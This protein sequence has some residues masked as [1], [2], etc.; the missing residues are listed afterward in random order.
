MIFTGLLQITDGFRSTGILI[1]ILMCFKSLLGGEEAGIWIQY[2]LKS[3]E[4]RTRRCPKEINKKYHQHQNKSTKWRSSLVSN[5]SYLFP[6]IVNWVPIYKKKCL[7]LKESEEKWNIRK[8][9]DIE[10]QFSSSHI[11]T[12]QNIKGKRISKGSRKRRKRIKIR[13][14]SKEVI[15]FKRDLSFLWCQQ[16]MLERMCGKL[17]QWNQWKWD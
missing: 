5:I 1:G 3:I 13:K 6:G 16:R 14:R 12:V 15:L 8:K 2:Y 11:N 17:Q 9:K 10:S 4:T 7:N